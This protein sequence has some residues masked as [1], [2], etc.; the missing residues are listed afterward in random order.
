LPLGQNGPGGP[1]NGSM[2]AA[3]LLTQRARNDPRYVSA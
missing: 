3:I 2:P 1:L